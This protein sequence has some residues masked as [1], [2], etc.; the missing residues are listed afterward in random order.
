MR[1]SGSNR[2]TPRL[3]SV[4]S[5]EGE[6]RTGEDEQPGDARRCRR[7]RSKAGEGEAGGGRGEG[8]EGRGGGAERERIG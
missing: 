1:R 5:I 6:Q 8:G 3:E 4:R 2:L 7:G